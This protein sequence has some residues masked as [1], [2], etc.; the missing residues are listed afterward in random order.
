M[1]KSSLK[2]EAKLLANAHRKMDEGTHI[3]KLF[4]S[5]GNDVIQLLEVST[6][7]AISGTIEPFYFDADK[8]DG[9]LRRCAMILLSDKEWADVQKKQLLLPEGWN[10][11]QAVDL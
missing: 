6:N 7:V 1:D 4:P 5:R 9:V 2:A 11:E 10:M 3:I 8:R